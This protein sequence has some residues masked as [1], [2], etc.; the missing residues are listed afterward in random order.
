MLYDIR[1][2]DQWA[3]VFPVRHI[4]KEQVLFVLP[5]VCVVFLHMD[6]LL[7]SFHGAK[8]NPKTQPIGI[9]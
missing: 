4:Q 9:C 3:E 5:D 1:K 7:N 6:F 2:S 8:K